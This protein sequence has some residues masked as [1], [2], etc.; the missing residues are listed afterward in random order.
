MSLAMRTGM[1][2]TDQLSAQIDRLAAIDT[3]PFPVISLYLN[4]QPDQHGRDH[5]DPFLRKEL[6]NRVRTYAAGGPEHESLEADA[7]RIREYVAGVDPSING[8]AVFACSAAELFEPMPLSAPVEQHRLFISSEPHLYPL[9]LLADEYPRYAV[10]LADTHLA[11]LFV[12]AANVLH[13]VATVEGTKTRR[14]KMGGWSQARYQRH[15]DNYHEQHA[16][17]VVDTLARLVREERLA[18]VVIMGDDVIVPLLREELPKDLAGRVVDVLKLDIRAPEHEILEAAAELMKQTGA[19]ND[20]DRVEVLFNAYRS[21]GLGVVGVE[22][23]ERALEIGQVEELLITGRPESLDVRRSGAPAEEPPSDLS[24][25]ERTADRLI[26][27]ATQ[28]SARITIVQDPSLLAPVGGA[29][30]LLRYKI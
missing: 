25:A 5:F 3:G 12:V 30:A 26:T 11:R 29:G 17:E 4:M 6:A 27:L 15:I 10:L 22:D 13:P 19:T 1:P 18:S 16:K 24:A 9:A 8:L 14:H 28:T 21:G 23:T 2:L 20:R 7:E